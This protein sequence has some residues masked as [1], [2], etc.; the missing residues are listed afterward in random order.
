MDSDR[1]VQRACRFLLVSSVLIGWVASKQAVR[2]EFSNGGTVSTR[3]FGLWHFCVRFIA[4][5]CILLIF[6]HQLGV[7]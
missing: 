1:C 4:P 3:W 2:D 5:V 6:L 7:I